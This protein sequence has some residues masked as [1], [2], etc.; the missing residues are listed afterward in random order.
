MKSLA[1]K[2]FGFA[3]GLALGVGLF[4]PVVFLTG[5]GGEKTARTPANA[6]AENTAHSVT[7]EAGGQATQPS[8]FLTGATISAAAAEAKHDHRPPHGGTVI[9]LGN[10]EYHLELVHDPAKGKLVAYVL[11]GELDRFIRVAAPSFLIIVVVEGR[12]E[13]LTFQP[14]ASKA[15]GE[16]VGDTSMFEAHAPWITSETVFDGK[17]EE[18]T[19]RTTTYSQVAFKFPKGNDAKPPK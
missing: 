8:N 4:G 16:A 1:R 7:P 18:L 5:C 10:E 14:V 12:D 11:D 2:H 19:V 15:T 3:M 17:L 13:V 9:S 6:P